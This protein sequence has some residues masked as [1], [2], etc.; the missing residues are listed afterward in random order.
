LPLINETQNAITALKENQMFEE[1][2]SERVVGFGEED[3]VYNIVPSSTQRRP[4]FS[5]DSVKTG[6]VQVKYYGGVGVGPSAVGYAA[7]QVGLHP[8]NWLP[9]VW[10]LVP[11][12]F[13]V[14][15]FSNVG[16]IIDAASIGNTGLKWSCKV[17][18]T[19][20]Q[21]KLTN[22]K[23]IPYYPSPWSHASG[24]IVTRGAVSPGGS[25]GYTT[26]ASRTAISSLVPSLE[27][28]FPWSGTQ[29]ITLS[30]LLGAS[31]EVRKLFKI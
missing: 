15:Y 27:F 24:P 30:A 20:T 22:W 17:V 14:D 8:S 21:N 10:E 12:S 23:F 18:R 7:K 11:Y 5:Y 3:F 29:W 9:T 31:A 1:T 19:R 6:Y 16:G 25:F 28:N 13:V 2:Y 4:G 26:K